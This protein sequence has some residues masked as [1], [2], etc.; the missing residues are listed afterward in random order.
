MNTG[1][2][3]LVTVVWLAV[4]IAAASIL[5]AL[6]QGLPVTAH[7]QVTD[8]TP[9][10]GFFTEPSV[11]INPR[12][13][14][15]VVVAYQDNAHIAYSLDAGKHWQAAPG[16]APRPR[17]R[18]RPQAHLDSTPVRGLAGTGM[19][20]RTA[21]ESA[22]H[23]QSVELIQVDNVCSPGVPGFAELGISPH[24]VENMLKQTLRSR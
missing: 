5:S 20:R 7:T 18:R 4:L 12:N 21:P 13:P 23:P 15:Q 14:Q 17:T 10:P 8:L 22:R 3:W 1:R 16:I 24:S 19:D 9:K 2:M 11:A 6:G